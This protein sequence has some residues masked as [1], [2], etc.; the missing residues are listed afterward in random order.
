MCCILYPYTCIIELQLHYLL[1]HTWLVG[2]R[3]EKTFK[4]M[5]SRNHILHNVMSYNILDIALH[6]QRNIIVGRGRG[7][8]TYLQSW[9]H[10]VLLPLMIEHTIPE[11]GMCSAYNRESLNQHWQQ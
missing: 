3:L 4:V 8:D 9:E 6:V 5:K 11:P 7:E 1:R 10:L 2:E